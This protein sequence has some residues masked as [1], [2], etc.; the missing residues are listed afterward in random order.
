MRIG[1]PFGF[2]LL[3]VLRLISPADQ[4]RLGEVHFP[5]SCKAAVQSQ[6]DSAVAL[7]HSFEFTEAESAFRK[8][9][10]D[11]PKCP[12]AAWG[13]ALATTE[14]SGANAPQKDLAKGW[15]EL[16]PWL[17]VKAGTVREQ[18]YVDAVRAMNVRRRCPRHV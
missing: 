9:E 14:R 4:S 5:T 2:V 8:V 6:F 18:M 1:V 3:F 7:L 12:I 16:Q 11:D 15:A 13:V 17:N 10:A